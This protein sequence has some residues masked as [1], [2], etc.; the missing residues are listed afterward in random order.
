VQALPEVRSPF[1]AYL[2][3]PGETGDVAELRE[4]VR[5]VA[6]ASAPAAAAKAAP[7]KAGKDSGRKAAGGKAKAAAAKEEEV[8]DSDATA[9]DDEAAAA[10]AAASAK[11]GKGTKTPP[12]AKKAKV[13]AA[14]KPDTGSRPSTPHGLKQGET[15]RRGRL[16]AEP[17]P[18]AA[19]TPPPTTPPKAE[20]EDSEDDDDATEDDEDAELGASFRLVEMD[21]GWNERWE[22]LTVWEE[23]MYEGCTWELAATLRAVDGGGRAL[24]V[25]RADVP[26]PAACP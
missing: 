2:P 10:A 18:V 19:K 8:E 7:A 1:E 5:R 17:R 6:A 20:P 12:T 22:Y 15:P 25:R 23:E 9:T 21:L 4:I 13:E 14:A 11:R 16:S 26:V 3:L 24:E